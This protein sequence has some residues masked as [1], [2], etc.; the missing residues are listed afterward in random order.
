MKILRTNNYGAGWSSWCSNENPEVAIFAL[1]YEPIIRALEIGGG[2][3]PTE[4]KEGAAFLADLKA[5]FGEDADMYIG[6]I[7][8]LVVDEVDGPFRI[9]EYDGWESVERISMVNWYVPTPSG[10]LV[11]V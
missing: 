3:R 9:N 7:D 11:L 10:T 5:K 6:G 1:T 4:E 8:N 2:Y